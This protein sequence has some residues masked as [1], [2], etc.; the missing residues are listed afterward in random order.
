M[1]PGFFAQTGAA[2]VSVDLPTDGP[3]PRFV[4]V[5]LTRMQPAQHQPARWP[6]SCLAWPGQSTSSDPAAGA[7]DLASTNSGTAVVLRFRSLITNEPSGQPPPSGPQTA[8]EP[9]PPTALAVH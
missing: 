5:T 9:T 6:R 4:A 3:L 1:N 8:A 2:Q 7:L